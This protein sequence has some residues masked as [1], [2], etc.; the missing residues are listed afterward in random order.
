M[1]FNSKLRNW[2]VP[3]LVGTHLSILNLFK[4][5]RADISDGRVPTLGVIKALDVIRNHVQASM[6]GLHTPQAQSCSRIRHQGLGI[7]GAA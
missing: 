4:V 5:Y 6:L 1:F 7:D 2:A 3:G